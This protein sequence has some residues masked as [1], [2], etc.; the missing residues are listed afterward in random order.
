MKNE[1]VIQ[2]PCPE[3]GR[4]EVR[5]SAVQIRSADEGSTIFYSC[6]CGHKYV[7]AKV[8]LC[9]IANIGKVEYKQ[10]RWKS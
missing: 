1:A 3:C 10:L 7:E 2:F 6:D 5:Y 9:L 8:H 4:K